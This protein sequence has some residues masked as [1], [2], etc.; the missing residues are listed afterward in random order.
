MID[1]LALPDEIEGDDLRLLRPQLEFAPLLHTALKR[2][3]KL[4]K[5]FLSWP[6]ANLSL[7]EVEKSLQRSVTA[8]DSSTA[9]TEKKYY[10]F[11]NELDI[12]VGC[13][14]VRYLPEHKCNSLGYWVNSDCAGHGY[15]TKALQLVIPFLKNLPIVLFIS[16]HNQPSKSLAVR[17]G[18]KLSGAVVGDRE[19][20]RYGSHD[21]LIYRIENH[22]N[23]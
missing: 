18:F 5:E 21:T 7:K 6:N 22:D 10:I 17:A 19:D 1:I 2:S 11:A 14:G 13:I 23:R 4:H 15:M 8:F 3:Y 20:A 12:L 9:E 16:E